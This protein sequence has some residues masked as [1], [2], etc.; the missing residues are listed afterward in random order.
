VAQRISRAKQR[1]KATVRSSA[2]HA[3]R[4]RR[5]VGGRLALLYL[6]FNEGYTASSGVTLHRFELSSEAIRLTRQLRARLPENASGRVT[7]ADAA[8]RCPPSART[9]V[10]WDAGAAS[11]AGPRL[12]GC[13][14]HRRGVRLIT[15]TL[16]SAPIGPYSSSRDRRV[17]AEA[18]GRG[19]DWLADPRPVRAAQQHRPGPMV[20]SIASSLWPWSTARGWSGAARQGG[21][22]PRLAGHTASPP[23]AP[24]SWSSLAT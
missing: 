15:E 9:R 17:H 7:G 12:M 4:I 5:A 14:V 13:G 23:S 16:A 3:G 8:D 2:C 1:I 19:T 6:I 21:V 10:E 18:A 11:R 20:T 22:R 24:T